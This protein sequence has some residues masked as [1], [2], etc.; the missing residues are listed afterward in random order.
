MDE[1]MKISQ[2]QARISAKDET[3]LPQVHAHNCLREIFKSSVLTLL[4][5]KSEKY[6]PTCLELAANSLKSEV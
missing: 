4:G 3:S 5:N 6:L 2:M 1:L